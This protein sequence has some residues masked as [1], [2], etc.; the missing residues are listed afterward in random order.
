MG[1]IPSPNLEHF[2]RAPCGTLAASGVNPPFGGLCR[3]WGQ[4]GY[5]LRTRAPVDARERQAFRVV[6]PRLACV[7]PVASVHPEPGSNSPLY[8]CFFLFSILNLIRQSIVSCFISPAKQKPA[9]QELTFLDLPPIP[10]LAE[11]GD[12][13]SF[14][15]VFLRLCNYLF[16]L[17]PRVIP[18]SEC[19]STAA[20][21]NNQTFH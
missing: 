13:V 7:K 18:E 20:F 6:S 17:R 14:L 21:P 15:P 2:A 8:I 12:A 3:G 9:G 11:T 16:E 19:K 4:V 5:A 10:A 1:R